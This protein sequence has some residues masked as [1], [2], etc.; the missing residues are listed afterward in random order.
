MV[1]QIF[2]RIRSCSLFL[3]DITN[4]NPNVMME[5]GI[6]SAYGKK[7]LLIENEELTKFQKSKNPFNI[8]TI[9]TIKYDMHSLNQ[10]KK[11]IEEIS[12]NT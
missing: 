7:I 6:A 2:D 4:Y 1:G 12:S 10:L 8:L 3:A 11:E 9:P 5:I